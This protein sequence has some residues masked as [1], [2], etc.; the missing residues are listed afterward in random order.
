MQ[1]NSSNNLCGE[2]KCDIISMPPPSSSSSPVAAQRADLAASRGAFHGLVICVT[3]LSKERRKQV[4]EVTERLGGQ[5]SLSLNPLCTHLVVESFT[6]RKLQHALKHGIN[7]G[8]FLVTL[9]WFV[10]S[11]KAN[12]RLSETLYSLH[13]AIKSG[14]DMDRLDIFIEPAGT[15]T[16][17]AFGVRDTVKKSR[18]QIGFTEKGHKMTTDSPIFG[19]SIYIDP[20]ISTELLNKVVEAVTCAGA[21]LIDQWFVGCGASYV[22][23]EQSS[24]QRYLGHVDN[25]VTPMWI[26]KASTE[27]P[28]QRCVCISSDLA[29][30]M[31]MLLGN[32]QERIS[33]QG[34]SGRCCSRDMCIFQGS[35][36]HEERL[37]VANH[38]KLM[39]RNRRL[40]R[41][42]VQVNP[43]TPGILLDTICWSVSDP[44]STAAVYVDS[45]AENACETILCPKTDD[46]KV[47]AS[48]ANL[49]RP[50]TESEKKGLILRHHFLTVL[51]PVDRFAEMGPSARTFFSDAGF[52]CLHVLDLIYA[53]YQESMPSEEIEAAIHT[54]SRNADEL[55]SAY[56]S[57]STAE[58]GQLVFRRIDFMGSRRSFE[59][60]KRVTIDNSGNVYELLLRT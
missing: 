28:M 51:F 13:Y 50:L 10:D 57:E 52:T 41:M 12:V 38:A 40:H 4:M 33:K 22:V 8:I 23:S 47:E 5:Y 6:G 11:V 25:V 2:E 1:W 48:F 29:R 27:T 16:C 37:Q 56:S 46:G 34:A 54:D 20:S 21:I 55:R 24:I 30:E 3:G 45:C 9:G 49:T 36:R 7:G 14:T 31:G 35:A 60:L 39:V 44:T 59:M 32:I 18:E 42:Q 15:C 17:L 43:I 26:L 19:R 58:A 53:F